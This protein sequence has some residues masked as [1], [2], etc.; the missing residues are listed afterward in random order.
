MEITMFKL[1][2][3]LTLML[4]FS[5][6][7]TAYS[8]GG[9]IVGNG[10]GGIC[11]GQICSTL[12]EAGL[13]VATPQEPY[14][15]LP[16]ATVKA[17]QELSKALPLGAFRE[18]LV[19]Q[20]VGRGDNFIKLEVADPQKIEQIRKQYAKILHDNNSSIDIDQ[21]RIFAFGRVIQNGSWVTEYREETYLLPDFFSL[22]PEQQAKVLIH[23]RNVRG[24]Q[25]HEH[26]IEALE[27]DGYIEDLSKDFSALYKNNF[28]IERWFELL[29]LFYDQPYASSLTMGNWLAWF[30]QSRNISFNAEKFCSFGYNSCSPDATRISSFY[31]ITPGFLR[32]IR[33]STP[34]YHYRG[35][36]DLNTDD[37][38]AFHK[39]AL[40]HCYSQMGTASNVWLLF[41]FNFYGPDYHLTLLNCTRLGS[42]IKL[43]AYLFQ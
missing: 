43:D 14:F 31:K 22:T 33:R 16:P 11:V 36:L 38:A 4:L 20:T 1:I 40:A 10:G 15:I 27:L 37:A 24:Q 12:A 6:N 28:R 29:E 9:D 39:S 41:P 5:L 7:P 17:L 18:D 21:V 35:P 3:Y 26:F 34:T 8:A 19:E 23:E 42:Q 25:H 30:Q 32:F 13:R 2:P